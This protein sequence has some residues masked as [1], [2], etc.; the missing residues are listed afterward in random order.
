M[1]N[2]F[3]FASSQYFWGG[4][5]LGL[6]ADPTDTTHDCYT[7]YVALQNVVNELLS[8]DY[9]TFSTATLANGFSATTVGYYV[10]YGKR[11]FDTQIN[12]FNMHT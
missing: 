9:S 4:L 12:Y 7:S 1:T 5:I 10:A 2:F 3:S 11:I 8:F 6:Q